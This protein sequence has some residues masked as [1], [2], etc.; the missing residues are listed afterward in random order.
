MAAKATFTLDDQTMERIRRLA[1]QSRKPQSQIV[2][3]AIAHYAGREMKLTDEERERKLAILREFAAR[4]PQPGEK[5]SLDVD[6]ELEELRQ[7][8]RE[9]WARP[10]DD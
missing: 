4:P 6:R 8:R 10:S 2:R 7:A 5:T 9:G 1:E 3:E